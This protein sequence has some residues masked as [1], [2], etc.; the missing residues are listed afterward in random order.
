[1]LTDREL[2]MCKRY[3]LDYSRYPDGSKE[4][5][6]QA[7]LNLEKA[8]SILKDKYRQLEA[9]K[10]GIEEFKN[11]VKKA[12]QELANQKEKAKKK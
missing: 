7:E 10:R 4:A 8:E 11:T 2:L 12:K 3:T 9:A 6:E 5:I 1:M